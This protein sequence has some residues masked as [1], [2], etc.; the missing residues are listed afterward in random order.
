MDVTPDE[1]DGMSTSPIPSEAENEDEIEEEEGFAEIQIALDEPV[2]NTTRVGMCNF[3]LEKLLPSL[4][5]EVKDIRGQGYTR[6]WIEHEGEKCRD[7]ETDS[8]Y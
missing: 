4:Q 2:T 1:G 5:L 6:Q 3:L 8:R 7:S